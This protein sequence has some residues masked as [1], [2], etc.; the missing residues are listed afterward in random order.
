MNLPWVGVIVVLGS[1]GRPCAAQDVRLEVEKQEPNPA[2]TGK[3]IRALRDEGLG[4]GE[5]GHA[6]A[7]SALARTPL[8]SVQALRETGMGWGEIAVYHGLKLAE[9]RALS[10]SLLKEVVTAD[11][12]P[13][14]DALHVGR[15]ASE[16]RVEE[17]Q[18]WLLRDDG[19]S[20]AELEHALIVARRAGRLPAEIGALR[21]AGLGWGDIARRFGLDPAELAG[22]AKPRPPERR[23][24]PSPARF[25]ELPF[26]IGPH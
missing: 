4:W 2:P 10:T 3:D 12:T 1:V 8:S 19:M 16:Y 24:P 6:L 23:P 7:V 20:W 5:I 26:G 11:R 17:K 21:D 14:A 9:V 13:S 18:L 15:L 25:Q 22:P